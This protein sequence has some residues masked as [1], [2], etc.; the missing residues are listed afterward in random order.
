M[1]HR[2]RHYYCHSPPYGLG[3]TEP[4]TAALSWRAVDAQLADGEET[5][6]FLVFLD[7]ALAVHQSEAAA[8]LGSFTS[9]ARHIYNLVAK[10][11]LDVFF[12]KPH[13]CVSD[14]QFHAVV[15]HVGTKADASSLRREFA[16]VVRQRVQHEER[17]R[18]VGFHPGISFSHVE[19]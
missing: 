18:P 1:G 11:L 17:E 5:I 13:A 15:L 12:R 16:G 3:Q 19:L 4:E 9:D 2:Y 8:V 10:D 14:A 7:D 6:G